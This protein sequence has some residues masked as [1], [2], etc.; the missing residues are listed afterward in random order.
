MDYLKKRFLNIISLILINILL[1]FNII[2]AERQYINTTI[3]T[4]S[5][6]VEGP[7][8]TALQ[9]ELRNRKTHKLTNTLTW[10]GIR[11]PISPQNGWKIANEYVKIIYTN[12]YGHWG[13]SLGTENTNSIIADPKY[14]GSDVDS[15]GGL[16]NVEN[17][18][19]VLQLVWHAATDT[20]DTNPKI[21][22]PYFDGINSYFT[23]SGW[24][25]KYII[26]RGSNN[27]WKTNDN[28]HLISKYVPTI[29]K[30]TRMGHAKI[31]YYS[32]PMNEY[33]RQ[34]GGG[35]DE[36]DILTHFK[37]SGITAR[38]KYFEEPFYIY[39]AADFTHAT[40]GNWRTTALILEMYSP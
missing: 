7:T 34:W 37:F 25:W 22:P 8:N 16:L 36:R 40:V 9:I 14:T 4:A 29:G 10:T 26:D 23:N 6:F 28:W 21:T 30:I 11:L 12:Y 17:P 35:P 13:I 2:Y 19:Q 15:A 38:G 3:F 18:E 27:F 5:L 32:V 24:L 33:G 39:F 20:N 1:L 31:N